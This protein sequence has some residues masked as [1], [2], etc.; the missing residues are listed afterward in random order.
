MGPESYHRTYS[1]I[2]PH[3][4]HQTSVEPRTSGM[5][6]TIK[7]PSHGI[8]IVDHNAVVPFGSIFCPLDFN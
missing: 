3:K 2:E 8:S 4:I 7:L 1:M 5:C 6:S